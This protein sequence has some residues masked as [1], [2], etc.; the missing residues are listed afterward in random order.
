MVNRQEPAPYQPLAAY[1]AASGFFCRETTFAPPV[2][3]DEVLTSAQ[4]AMNLAR[5]AI[6]F[7]LMLFL[8]DGTSV[9]ALAFWE[10][11]EHLAR[12][13]ATLAVIREESEPGSTIAPFL[14]LWTSGVEHRRVGEVA[15]FLSGPSVPVSEHDMVFWRPP[16]AVRIIEISGLQ[17]IA[18]LR[19][20]VDRITDIRHSLAIQRSPGLQ[21][22]VTVDYGEGNVAGYL[23]FR[24][25]EEL[26]NYR[27]SQRRVELNEQLSEIVEHAPAARLKW[28]DGT[29]HAWFVRDFSAPR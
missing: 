24:S 12:Y 2:T 18:P 17:D 5:S 21:F 19:A 8:H 26:E 29:L 11:L 9:R 6:G 7:R 10:T 16:G 20:W 4:R 3:V 23:G 28:V 14:N 15:G 1:R 25:C 13:D 22:L 27:V